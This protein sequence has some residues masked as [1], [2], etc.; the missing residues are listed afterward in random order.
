MFAEVIFALALT[1]ERLQIL[2]HLK[3]NK[4]KALYKDCWYLVEAIGTATWEAEIIYSISFLNCY[5]TQQKY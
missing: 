5:C 3:N 1:L 2:L 4:P